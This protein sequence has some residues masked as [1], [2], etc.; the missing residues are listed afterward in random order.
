M[1]PR[2]SIGLV[3]SFCAG[4]DSRKSASCFTPA[5]PVPSFSRTTRVIASAGLRP[6]TPATVP[7][8]RLATRTAMAGCSRRLRRD[9]PVVS[10]PR[11]PASRLRTIWRVRCGVR[12]RLTP[13]TRSEPGK[14]TRTGMPGTWCAAGGR[15]VAAMSDYR[16]PIPG[17]CVDVRLG[18]NN[19][20]IYGTLTGWCRR[21]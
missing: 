7:L 18:G 5:S 11:R 10:I 12:R 20:V 13:S 4:L 17:G 15:V 14:S 19:K 2:G 9:C 1:R 8:P 6:T 21:P 16:D 3:C